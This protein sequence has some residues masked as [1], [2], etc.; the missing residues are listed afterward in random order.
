MQLVSAVAFSDD[1]TVRAS[2]AHRGI[3]ARELDRVDGAPVSVPRLMLATPPELIVYDR[4]QR[5]PYL[6]DRVARM[7]LRLPARPLDRRELDERL[8]AGDRRQGFVLYRTACP[9]CVSC[10][11][12]RIPAAGYVLTRSQ[13]RIVQRG[14]QG[15]KVLVGPPI[16]NDRRVAI[17]NAHKSSRGLNDGQPPIDDD[18]YR[19]FL[20][21][22]CCESFE[23]S[24][25]LEGELVGVAIVDRGERSLSAVYCCYDPAVS[26]FGIG[27]Y[28]ILKQLELCRSWSLD[29]LYLGLYIAECDAML[30]KARYR[31]HQ[32]LID[33][34]WRTFV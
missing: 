11:P 34:E 6:Q 2:V 30:Y 23:L 17:Y 1:V 4:A 18:G 3:L 22:T 32:R 29:Y 26:R 19:D 13:R 14:D 27:T 28:S 21:S 8:E 12:I 9:Q 20:V 16:V 15:L 5:C 7:P 25:Y 31:P 33:G 10:E 24:Y